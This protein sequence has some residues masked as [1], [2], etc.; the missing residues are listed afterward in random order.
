MFSRTTCMTT[1]VKE[2]IRPEVL[3]QQNH[4]TS[5]AYSFPNETSPEEFVL[6]TVRAI[7]L[8]IPTVHHF[9][10]NMHVHIRERMISCFFFFFCKKKKSLSPRKRIWWHI[11]HISCLP[12]SEKLYTKNNLGKIKDIHQNENMQGLLWHLWHLH[13]CI[14]FL[15][16]VQGN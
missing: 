5:G 3:S 1:N 6:R 4:C 8:R 11:I 2:I 10:P 9:T 7:A 12:S 15:T 13:T 16:N 14:V